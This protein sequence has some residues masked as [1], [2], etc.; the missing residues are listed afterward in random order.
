[1]S[2]VVKN[3][4]DPV[5]E[6][7]NLLYFSHH[8]EWKEEI[9]KELHKYGLQGDVFFDKHYK[10]VEKYL[11][12]F[13]KY[14]VTTPQETYF[15]DDSNDEALLLLLTLAVEN[16][17]YIGRKSL[18]EPMDIRS[19]IAYCLQDN[20][21][22]SFLPNVSDMPQLPDDKS[23]IEFLDTTD[24]KNS[25]KW[26]MLELMRSPTYYLSMLFDMITV[27]MDAFE[28]AKAAVAKPLAV[29]ME[30]H[31]SYHD[32]DFFKIAEAYTENIVVY[33][34]LATPLLQAVLYSNGYLGILNEHLD[35]VSRN[36]DPTK[37]TL[38]RQLKSLSDKSKLDILCELKQS[39]K[40]NL[41][42]SES[43][44]LS[45]STMS[46]HMNALLSCGFVTV[47]KKNGKVYYCLQESVIRTFLTGLEQLIL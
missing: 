7:I 25:E 42:L 27:N 41:E 34:S 16:R 18:P 38:I 39:S 29:L 15:F 5:Y 46:H 32:K 44:G 8:D 23:I 36:T 12:T 24:I 19:F 9:I 35:V 2:I 45:P 17:E 21:D 28:K 1:M 3:E 40:Y 13:R 14:K 22:S 37:E 43:L 47:E 10:I 31:S 20:G 30:K 11:K 6:I 4:L 26:Y 33:T